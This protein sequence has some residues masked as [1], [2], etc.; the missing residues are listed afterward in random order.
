MESVKALLYKVHI[1]NKGWGPFVQ[2]GRL[3]GTTGEGLQI[4][5]IRIQGAD[6]YRVHVEGIGWMEWVGEDQVA[7]TTGKGLRIEAIEI[8]AD[9]LNYQV[10]V[11]NIGWMDFARSGEMAGSEGGGLRIEAIRML[12]S[13]EPIRVDDTRSFFVVAPKPIP[14]PEPNPTKLVQGKK[15]GKIYLAVGHGTMTNGVWDPGCVDG[16]H[17]E[18]DL[19]YSIGLQAVKR[20]REL[21]LTVVSDADTKNNKNMVATVAEANRVGA[22][23]YISLHC[24]YNKAPS[25]TL[26]IVYPGSQS[27]IRLAQ[28]LNGS[29]KARMELGTRGILQRD[30]YEVS[31]T[32][33]TACI[34]ETGSIRA[35]INKLLDFNKY[36]E[37]IAQGIYD[38]F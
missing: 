18:A 22:D 14:I 23:V 26:P 16:P 36:A 21:G 28:C 15:S 38:Y 2:E 17:T 37:A 3:A 30:D 5:A 7:G 4:E 25:G 12:R 31:A 32:N 35:D 29:V 1:Q 8:K 13:E 33:M 19:M 24:D 27:G 11:Q 10:H 34:F 6:R 9:D 20:L